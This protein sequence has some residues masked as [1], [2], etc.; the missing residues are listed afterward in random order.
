MG[1]LFAAVGT[2]TTGFGGL[3]TVNFGLG[4]LIINIVN[5]LLGN[6]NIRRPVLDILGALFDQPLRRRHRVRLLLHVGTGLGNQLRLL[7][8]RRLGFGHRL[9]LFGNGFRGRRNRG[10]DLNDGAVRLL[11]GLGLL[12]DCGGGVLRLIGRL[13]G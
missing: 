10:I 11:H 3:G 13:S 12:L 1:R 4:N 9:G 2:V 5:L 7:F 6:D 8:D